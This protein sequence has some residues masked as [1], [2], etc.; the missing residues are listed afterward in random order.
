LTILWNDI[1][2]RFNATSKS[3]QKAD[4]N[5][6]IAV[7]MLQALELYVNDLRDKF[8]QLERTA[9]DESDNAEYTDIHRRVP[10]R[11]VRITSMEGHANDTVLSGTGSE[12][13]K[14]GTFCLS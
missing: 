11:S 2:G 7:D 12:K 3:L 8:D 6:S 13:F 14:L 4:M 10:K 5:I 9:K 1:L